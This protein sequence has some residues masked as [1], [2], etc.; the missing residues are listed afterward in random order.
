MRVTLN[1]EHPQLNRRYLAA[2]INTTAITIVDAMDSAR[3]LERPPPPPITL[4]PAMLRTW[5][6]QVQEPD[7]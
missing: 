1:P 4:I 3:K 6:G 2:L 7:R 5:A